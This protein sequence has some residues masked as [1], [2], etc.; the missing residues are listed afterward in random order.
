MVFIYLAFIT[1]VLINGIILHDG[2]WKMCEKKYPGLD[3]YTQNWKRQERK[4]QDH[5]N[6]PAPSPSPPL[7]HKIC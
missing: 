2:T 7:P 1:F 3:Y 5:Y 4:I 6:L